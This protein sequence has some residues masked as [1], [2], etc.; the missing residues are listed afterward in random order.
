MYAYDPQSRSA[1]SVAG[2]REV[3]L[4]SSGRV[5]A[6]Y[7]AAP[8]WYPDPTRRHEYRWWSTGWT[9]HVGD[10]GR[11]NLDP[12]RRARRRIVGL[13]LLGQLALLP[14]VGFLLIGGDSYP[15][16]RVGMT[17]Q[18][19]EMQ[20]VFAVCPGERLHRIEL[21]RLAPDRDAAGTLLW[22]VAGDAAV[23]R[24]SRLAQ[25]WLA[26]TQRY[27]SENR[28]RRPIRWRWT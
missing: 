24:H 3:P 27:S 25:T 22:A 26:S 8:G 18:R 14:F 12:V 17:S 19:G 20:I 16:S 9:N 15:V 1:V 11:A 6:S 28:C 4:V 23:P 2:Q 13:V 21:V 5:K 10:G 7:H